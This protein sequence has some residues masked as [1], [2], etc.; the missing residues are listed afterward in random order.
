MKHIS[1]LVV[2]AISGSLVYF[3]LAGASRLIKS[4]SAEQP[5]LAQSAQSLEQRLKTLQNRLNEQWEYTLSTQPE[6]ASIIG[7]KRYNDR[8]SDFSQKAI[9]RD[10]KQTRDFLAKFEAIDTTGFPS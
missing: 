9:D 1:F 7:D 8:L 4:V 2:A 5:P 6:F 10:I 3:V